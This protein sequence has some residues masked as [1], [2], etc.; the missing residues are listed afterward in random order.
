MQFAVLLILEL[1]VIVHNTIKQHYNVY[2][3]K[4]EH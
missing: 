4:T 1:S 2:S 3:L